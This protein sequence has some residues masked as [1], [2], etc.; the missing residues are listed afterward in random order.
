MF[1]ELENSI[2]IFFYPIYPGEELKWDAP[3]ER[4][5]ESLPRSDL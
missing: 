2:I 3:K 5:F 1:M 4:H